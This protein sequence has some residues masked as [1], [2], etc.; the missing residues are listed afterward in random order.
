MR[1][2]NG[3]VAFVSAHRKQYYMF[4]FD[5]IFDNA[6]FLIGNDIAKAYL[7][8]KSELYT[9][10]QELFEQPNFDWGPSYGRDMLDEL[11]YS[12]ETASPSLFSLAN[13]IESLRIALAIFDSDRRNGKEVSPQ[14]I[15]PNLRVENV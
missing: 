15:D 5:A 4:Q 14:D 2:E 12:I 7:P 3:S 10:Y 9:G 11:I 13:A 8:G 1:M 6:R